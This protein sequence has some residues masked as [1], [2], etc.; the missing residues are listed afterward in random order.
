MYTKVKLNDTAVHLE[1]FY[2][3]IF[4]SWVLANFTLLIALYPNTTYTE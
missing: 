1:S 4:S 2:P 3:S